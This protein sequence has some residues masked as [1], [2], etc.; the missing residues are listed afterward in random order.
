MTKP[1]L[2]EYTVTELKNLRKEIN[3]ELKKR[4]PPVKKQSSSDTKPISG[5]KKPNDKKPSDKKATDKKS[6]D[7]KSEKNAKFTRGDMK[8]VLKRNNLEYRENMKKSELLDI[9]KKNNMVHKVK[10]YHNNKTN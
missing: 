8:T 6:G 5:D 10:E 2:S 1:I 9:I 4:E 3:E 7:K